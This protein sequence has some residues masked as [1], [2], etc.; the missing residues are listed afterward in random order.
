[1]AGLYSK[2][3]RAK[4]NL[5][6]IDTGIDELKDRFVEIALKELGID[7]SKIILDREGISAGFYHSRVAKQLANI[8]SREIYVF[9]TA[10]GFSRNYVAGMFDISGHIKDGRVQIRH[11]TPK[12]A[13]MLDNLGV[14]TRGDSIMNI[15]A[16][17]GL[18][19]GVSIM[20]GRIARRLP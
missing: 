19:K 17:I 3:S 12:D 4:K 6:C 13:I 18:I 8:V 16:F 20:E 10:N 11:V 1:M 15:G 14:H 2:S 7:P 5:V 9:K